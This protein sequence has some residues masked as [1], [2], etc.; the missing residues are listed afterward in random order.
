MGL[1]R[2]LVLI[3]LSMASFSYEYPSAAVTGSLISSLVIGQRN[4]SGMPEH[5]DSFFS[6]STFLRSLLHRP[7]DSMC[8][9]DSNVSLVSLSSSVPSMLLAVNLPTNPSRP[10]ST[11]HADTSSS[12]QSPTS[13]FNR[14]AEVLPERGGAAAHFEKWSNILH[15]K[16]IL[17]SR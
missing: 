10:S 4:S 5:T 7:N 14:L 3:Q 1:V 6:S 17:E 15:C 12:D 2:F 11:S 9:S 8:S 16:T 13:F